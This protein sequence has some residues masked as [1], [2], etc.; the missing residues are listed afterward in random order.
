MRT[1][2]DSLPPKKVRLGLQH[3]QENVV[4]VIHQNTTTTRTTIHQLSDGVLGISLA[5]L[6][7][8]GHF[9]Y[10]PLAC[11]MFLRASELNQHFTKITTGESV[12]SSI[13]CAKRYFQ[14]KG[15]GKAQFLF[16]WENAARYGRLDVMEWAHQQGYSAAWNLERYPFHSIGSIVCKKSSRVWTTLCFAVVERK[17][18]P[19]ES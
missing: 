16:F 6:G 18:V 19:L 5:L 10:G 3:N 11:K 12:T 4:A 8:N 9:R 15:T 2:S 13:S 1:D 7:G 17:W 14:D